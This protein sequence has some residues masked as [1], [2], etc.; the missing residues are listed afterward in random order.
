MTNRQKERLEEFKANLELMEQENKGLE[1]PY[2]FHG[3]SYLKYLHIKQNGFKPGCAYGVFWTKHIA[4]A[5]HFAHPEGHQTDDMPVILIA[6][7]SNILKSGVAV[8][9]L[10]YDVMPEPQTWQ[11]SLENGTMLVRNGWHVDNLKCL[12]PDWK[13]LP[14]H[15]Q[16]LQDREDRLNSIHLMQPTQNAH[17]TG[18]EE[19]D[20]WESVHRFEFD[21]TKNLDIESPRRKI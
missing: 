19:I 14:L 3:T 10:N 6:R 13:N 7:L 2:L 18:E 8:P 11:E 4:T 21:F 5:L 15:P 12:A 17:Y 20:T 1:D 9:D 16:A